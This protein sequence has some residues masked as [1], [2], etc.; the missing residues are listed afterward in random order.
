MKLEGFLAFLD[1]PKES[2]AEAL[3]ELL[4]SHIDVKILTGDRLAVT[5]YVSKSVGLAVRGTLSGSQ[6]DGCLIQSLP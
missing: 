1:P 6:I 4:S 5:E 2:A 3:R